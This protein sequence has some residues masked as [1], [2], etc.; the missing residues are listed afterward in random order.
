M[1]LTKDYKKLVYEFTNNKGE[2][3]LMW[4]YKQIHEL[5]YKNSLMNIWV[6]NG[7]L[8]SPMVSTWSL[9]LFVFDKDGNCSNKYNPQI[10]PN[11]NQLNFDYIVPSTYNNLKKL[12]HKCEEMANA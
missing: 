3:V 4:I 10:I 8:K 5:D 9:D 1:K 6:K 12:L 7:W 2:R 11:R